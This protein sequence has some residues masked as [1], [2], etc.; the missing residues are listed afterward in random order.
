[1]AL[2]WEAVF[3]AADL[4]CSAQMAIWDGMDSSAN[5]LPSTKA[6]LRAAYFPDLHSL[7]ELQGSAIQQIAYLTEA[8][9]EAAL[10]MVPGSASALLVSHQC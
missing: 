3:G 7:A 8:P 5:G 4:R 9:E 6:G 2:S 10:P 1:M